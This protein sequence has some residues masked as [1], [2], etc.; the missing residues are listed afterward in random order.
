MTRGLQNSICAQPAPRTTTR[1]PAFPVAG[2]SVTLG[3]AATAVPVASSGNSA[4]E[5]SIWSFNVR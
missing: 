3:V 1:V 4:L 5:N 2:V